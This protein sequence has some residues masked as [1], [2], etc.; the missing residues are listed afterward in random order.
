[1]KPHRRSLPAPAP[2]CSGLS[3]RSPA[4]HLPRHRRQDVA[5]RC[6]TRSGGPRGADLTLRPLGGPPSPA[7]SGHLKTGH[8][9]YGAEALT[10]GR[11]A[12]RVGVVRAAVSIAGC[13]QNRCV[14]VGTTTERISERLPI[15]MVENHDE[16]RNTHDM[17]G[18]AAWNAR[19]RSRWPDCARLTATRGVRRSAANDAAVGDEITKP[20][21]GRVRVEA[22]VP[23]HRNDE[24]RRDSGLRV[25]SEQ[26][27]AARSAHE[28]G[29]RA[30]RSPSIGRSRTR[31]ESTPAARST[32]GVCS[33]CR[34]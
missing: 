10:A 4:S 33:Q 26:M 29:E 30:D 7:T 18:I 31:T 8:H 32:R 3:S 13:L 1:M 9:G 34:A 16:L 11:S 22:R 21:V 19:C 14:D 5:D 25:R 17:H 27:I 23:Q 12:W 28:Y 2:W 20:P 6:A 15:A 24:R